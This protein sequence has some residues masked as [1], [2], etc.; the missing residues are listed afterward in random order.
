MDCDH[1]SPYHPGGVKKK[2]EIPIKFLTVAQ[3]SIFK[4]FLTKKKYFYESAKRGT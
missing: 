3:S 1:F 2:F 4:R